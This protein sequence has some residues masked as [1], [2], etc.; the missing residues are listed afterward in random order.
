M[1]FLS[2]FRFHEKKSTLCTVVHVEVLI[3]F[4]GPYCRSIQTARGEGK[5]SPYL[6]AVGEDRRRGAWSRPETRLAWGFVGSVRRNGGA[7][8]RLGGGWVFMAAGDGPGWRRNPV[9]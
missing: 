2:E 1:H 9:P 4:L 3:H 5:E 6:G 7:D 8:C